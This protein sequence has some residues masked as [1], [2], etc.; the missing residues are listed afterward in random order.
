MQSSEV[1]Y[2][3]YMWLCVH[4]WLQVLR[5]QEVWS[6]GWCFLR[7]HLLCVY[8][9]AAQ[10]VRYQIDN[11]VVRSPYAVWQQAG[12]P[13]YPSYSLLQQMRDAAVSGRTDTH[14]YSIMFPA[15]SV[16][17]VFESQG[18][19]QSILSIMITGMNRN[20]KWN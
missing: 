14:V 19:I 20:V 7:P 4:V 13:D 1:G 11:S 15:R 9:C 12:K 10:Y 16:C 3:Y 2:I 6:A 17:M 18:K 8:V 5:L